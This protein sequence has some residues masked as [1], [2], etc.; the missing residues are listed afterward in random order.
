MDRLKAENEELRQ[1]LYTVKKKLQVANQIS[2]DL[3][4]ELE[5]QVAKSNRQLEQMRTEH[6]TQ[7][8]AQEAQIEQLSR[9][10]EREGWRREREI[11]RDREIESRKSLKL[12]IFFW[13]V[14]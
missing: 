9:Y 2:T 7:L 6:A 14:Y 11:E 1:E 3:S 12:Y 8:K 4:D 13:L 5:Q 10:R